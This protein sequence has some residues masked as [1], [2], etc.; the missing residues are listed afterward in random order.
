MTP[1]L[2]RPYHRPVETPQRG[3]TAPSPTSTAWALLLAARPK[4][5]TKNLIVYFALFFTINEAWQ[6]S[7]VS[8]WSAL[9]ARSTAAF[10][11]FSVLSSGIYLVNDVFDVESDRRHPRKRHRPIPSGRLPIPVAWASAAVF[12]CTALVLSFLLETELGFVTTAYLATMLAYTA[13]LKRVLFTDVASISAG[14]VLRA[15]AGAAAIQVPISAWL[16]ICTGLGALFIALS[17]RRSELETAGEDAEAQR[18][19]L[20]RYTPGLLGW[21]TALTVIATLVAY[22]VY[23]FTAD[24][25]PDNHAMALTIPFVLFGLLRYAYLVHFKVLGENPEDILISDVPLMVGIVMWLT[26]AA[27]VLIAF[28]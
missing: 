2:G 13:V 22:S 15:V 5:W 19:I 11:L 6:L 20:K 7:D 12:I 21:L 16:Y 14:F 1:R 4:Q 28:R 24:N 9:L 8:A 25:L 17:K 23:T 26:T 3:G 18:D 10:C 27:I